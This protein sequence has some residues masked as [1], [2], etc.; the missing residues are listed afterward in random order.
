MVVLIYECVCYFVQ[1][2]KER[3]DSHV[4]KLKERKKA[5]ETRKSEK[6]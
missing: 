6:N 1:K 3:K 4:K 2:N 5:I